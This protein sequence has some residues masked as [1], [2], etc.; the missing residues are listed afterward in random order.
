MFH[1]KNKRFLQLGIIIS[2]YACG[3]HHEQTS[4]SVAIASDCGS[5]GDV[6]VDCGNNWKQWKILRMGTGAFGQL[7]GDGSRFSKAGEDRGGR[8]FVF[9]P[10][11]HA[12]NSA[13]I[14]GNIEISASGTVP[15]EMKYTLG[16]RLPGEGRRW[17][18]KDITAEVHSTPAFSVD[19]VAEVPGERWHVIG[20]RT[21]YF[22]ELKQN[23][24]DFAFPRQAVGFSDP[25]VRKYSNIEVRIFDVHP[26]L[27][28]RA[29]SS[30]IRANYL[31]ME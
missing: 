29:Y 19:M 1:L 9:G 5:H 17:K 12:G 23:G 25:S 8:Y 4:S 14:S 2:L 28:I 15:T 26:S 31:I 6:F 10:Y 13:L 3:T 30:E 22:R 11:V 16:P 27:D 18:T 20:Q 7:E 21:V 24:W